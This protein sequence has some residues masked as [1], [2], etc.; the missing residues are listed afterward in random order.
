MNTDNNATTQQLEE[1]CTSLLRA[2][3][4]N[5]AREGLLR[6]PHRYARAL[7][8][9]TS[10]YSQDLD[11]IVNGAIFSESYSEMVVVKGIEFYSLC[12][13]HIL[14]FFGHV[15]VAYVPGGKII[16]LSKIPRIVEMFAR[17][18][19]VQ[20]R[21]SDQIT[22]ALNEVLSPRGVAC[23]VE[24]RHLCMMMRGVQI[25]SSATVTS[26][27]RGVFMS[28]EKTRAEFLGLRGA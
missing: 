15:T 25:Q 11:K 13:H 19:Q 22:S 9:L 28:D 16:G 27:M 1:V 12:E 8:D 20:E 21:L 24:A 6:T 14:P 2:V 5:P 26:S 18:L 7:Q 3:G 17:R 23:T 10:G 4:E